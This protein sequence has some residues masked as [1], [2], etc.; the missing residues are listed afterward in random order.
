MICSY[1]LHVHLTDTVKEALDFYAD[2]RTHDRKVNETINTIKCVK[3]YHIN[4]T[5]SI[6]ISILM[7]PSRHKH[8][9]VT[10]VQSTSTCT[11]M[12]MYH[13]ICKYMY[14]YMYVSFKL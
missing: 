14:M 3:S 4:I 9:Y 10:M 5:I 11:Y 7:C 1:L 13:S 8:I 12:Y 6:I 2:A